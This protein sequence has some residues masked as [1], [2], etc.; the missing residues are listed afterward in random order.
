MRDSWTYTALTSHFLEPFQSPWIDIQNFVRVI[1]R[2]QA[3]A[4]TTLNKRLLRPRM[5]PNL[6]MTAPPSRLKM[7]RSKERRLCKMSV[8]K[9]TVQL[10]QRR[11]PLWQTLR[12]LE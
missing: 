8:T 3:K 4:A 10:F 5:Q 6:D 12:R 7:Q 9:L 2:Q 11:I 1:F